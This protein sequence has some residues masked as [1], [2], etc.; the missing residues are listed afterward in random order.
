MISISLQPRRRARIPAVVSVG[1]LALWCVLTVGARSQIAA[2]A[3]PAGETGV[4]VI[5]RGQEIVRI[6]RGVGNIGPAERARMAT[7]RL[8]QFVRDSSFDA[9]RVTV[10]HGESFSELVYDDRVLGVITDEDAQAVGR[11][12]PEFAQQIRDRL[13]YVIT[14]TREEFSVWSIVMGGTWAALATGILG[15]LLWLLARVR[16]RVR[17]RVDT[18]FQRLTIPAAEAVVVRTTRLGSMAHGTVDVAAAAVA[19]ALAAVWVQI[20]LQVLPWSRPL[21]RLIYRYV[22]EPIRTLWFGLLGYVPNLFYL[23]VIAL[24]TL[25]LLRVL[26]VL[27]REIEAGHL[28][29][30]SFPSDWAEPTYKLVRALLLAVAFVGAFPYIPGSRTPAFQGISLFL[31]LLVSLSSSSALSNIIAGTILTYT[32]AFKVGDIVRIGD[33][34]GEVTVKRLLATHV[35]TY[36]NVVVSIP[37]SLIL[38]TQVLNYTT[39][40]AERGLVAHTSVTIGYDAP[41]RKVHELL[42]AAAMRTEG[43]LEDPPPFVLQTALNDFSITYE[44]NAFVSSP[45]PLPVT[46]STLHANIQDGFN[47]AGVE[48]MSPNYFALRDGNQVTTPRHHLPSDYVAPAFRLRNTSSSLGVGS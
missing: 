12:R 25:L 3:Q 1:L 41:W 13:V 36:K 23:G 24:I 22:S 30:A 44:I 8:G 7:A 2:I 40:A 43:V 15:V 33:T 39:L 20:V 34:F 38:T 35:R 28:R 14:S 27:F 48:I 26:H 37:N 18:W 4:P 10:R 47:E 21:A 17:R 11:P 5:Y 45:F 42:I 19:V 46:Y 32:R 16:R 29:F 31:G 9:T 6:Y